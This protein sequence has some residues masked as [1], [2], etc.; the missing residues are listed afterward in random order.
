MTEEVSAVPAYEQFYLIKEKMEVNVQLRIEKH[1][2]ENVSAYDLRAKGRFANSSILPKLHDEL[3]TAFYTDD[4]QR[5]LDEFKR[6]LRFQRINKAIPWAF[7]VPRVVATVHDEFGDDDLI[8][9]DCT[10]D[11]FTFLPHDGGTVELSFRVKT[12]ELSEEQVIQLLRCNGQECT[13]SVEVAAAEE[14]QDYAAQADLLSREPMSDARAEAEKAFKN[15]L[16]AQS[17]EE[18]LGLP[19]VELEEPPN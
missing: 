7:E 16:G 6:K 2:D 8:I 4:K 3:L 10:V 1:G 12:K 17:P 19:E 11:K 14:D 5:D 18:L 15:P 13:I 9:T